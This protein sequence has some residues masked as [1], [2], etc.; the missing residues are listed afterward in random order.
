MRFWLL[1]HPKNWDPEKCQERIPLKC[2]H[3][4]SSQGVSHNAS[5]TC[6]RIPCCLPDS[7]VSLPTI[8]RKNGDEMEEVSDMVLS[9]TITI[10]GIRSLE[11]PAVAAA[12]PKPS[13]IES[14]EDVVRSC[15]K[16]QLPST[17]T[18]DVCIEDETLAEKSVKR[19]SKKLK[20]QRRP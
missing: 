10:S 18:E 13:V 6:H 7:R 16:R 2:H 1:A 17:S 15:R 5:A 12:K 20:K 8:L 11:L 4:S 19:A 14:V 9:G 3:E